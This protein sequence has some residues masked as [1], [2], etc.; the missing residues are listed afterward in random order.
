MAFL[1][2]SLDLQ[3]GFSASP[4]PHNESLRSVS[5]ADRFV[6]WAASGRTLPSVSSG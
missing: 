4:S 1:P 3:T 5:T 2:V 6:D